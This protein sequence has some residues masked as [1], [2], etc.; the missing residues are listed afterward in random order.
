MNELILHFSQSI[1]I[2]LTISSVDLTLKTVP[3]VFNW[4]AVWWTHYLSEIIWTYINLWTK[5][6]IIQLQSVGGDCWPPSDLNICTKPG[7]RKC[8]VSS[9]KNNQKTVLAL[10]VAC[11]YWHYQFTN[12][13]YIFW[14]IRHLGYLLKM[15]CSKIKMTK[16]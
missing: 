13:D 3:F 15:L 11:W 8:A 7:Y 9:S 6:Y 2:L 4:I 16:S 10:L 12:N 1:S 5:N 14:G